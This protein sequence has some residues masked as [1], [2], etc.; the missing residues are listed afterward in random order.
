MGEEFNQKKLEGILR[1]NVVSAYLDYA[2][3]FGERK[4][5]NVIKHAQNTLKKIRR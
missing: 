1:D 4:A 3:A 2:M 5:Q